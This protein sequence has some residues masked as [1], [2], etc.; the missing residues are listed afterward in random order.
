[1]KTRLWFGAAALLLAGGCSSRQPPRVPGAPPSNVEQ[2]L[3]SWYGLEEAG[4]ATASGEPMAPEK[5]TAAH[6][7]LPFGSFVRVTDLDTGRRVDVI[8]ND[9]GPFVGGRIIDLSFAAAR[10]LGIVEKGVARVRIEVIGL[11]GPLAERRWR[12]QVGSFTQERT[13]REL[14]TQI[15]SEGYSP[16]SVS[17]FQDRGVIYYRV[18]VGEYRERDGAVALQRQL[19]RTGHQGFA[20]LAAA[21]SP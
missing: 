5:L 12:V 4:R 16:V 15:Q 17:Q 2:G 18:W 14:A 13:A 10:D 6:K 21:T 7:T 20:L 11:K 3:A 19:Q 1:M 8:I 9:R